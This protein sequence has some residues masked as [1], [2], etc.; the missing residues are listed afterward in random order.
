M[1]MADTK[2]LIY[3][4]VS[5]RRDYDD[6]ILL[7]GSLCQMILNAAARILI[8]NQ[9]IWW[10]NTNLSLTSSASYSCPIMTSLN[11]LSHLV[12]YALRVKGSC[13]L[14]ADIWQSEYIWGL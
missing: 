8:K 4:F 3:G 6:Y 9:K 7:S 1:S 11:L 10:Y 2:I 13:L 5:S 12:H 14:P